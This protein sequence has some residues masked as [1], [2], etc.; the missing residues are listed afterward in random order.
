MFIGL[1]GAPGSAAEEIV[2]CLTREYGFKHVGLSKSE[3]NREEDIVLYENSEDLLTDVTIHWRENFVTCD[4]EHI[5]GIDMYIKR[6]F[7]LLITVDSSLLVKF[8]RYT[9]TIQQVTLEDFC[10]L[11]DAFAIEVMDQHQDQANLKIVN[12]VLDDPKLLLTKIKSLDLLNP[13]RLRPSWDSY[14]MKFTDFAAQRS[15]C[16]RR[17]V[18]CVI[19]RNNRIIA[20]GY[21]G[22]ARGVK[23]CNEGGC[24][25]CN[26]A[27][28]N[29]TGVGLSTCLCLH[30]EENALLEAGRARV[31]DCAILYCNTCPCLT[32]TI[33]IVQCGITEVVYSQSYSMDEASAKVFK[34]AGVKF[35]Q[36]VP[37]TQG[38]VLIQ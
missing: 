35:R 14:F 22:T 33:K 13:N 17:R 5:E 32:C 18:G 1:L 24:Y 11:S 6:P 29:G 3:K 15:N 9:K 2:H 16:M 12:N 7:F 36:F 10:Q 30:A 31:E 4:V 34:E 23:N 28:V 20:T 27:A 21:N 19:V 25:R 8:K 26:N 37:P 38:T